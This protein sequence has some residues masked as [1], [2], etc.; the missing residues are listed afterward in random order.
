MM[1]YLQLFNRDYLQNCKVCRINFV[2]EQPYYIPE[3]R[4]FREYYVF[5]SNAAAASAAASQVLCLITIDR[6][7]Y[8]LLIRNY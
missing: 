3:K 6:L 4:K 7:E 5:V 2:N 1:T 8:Y